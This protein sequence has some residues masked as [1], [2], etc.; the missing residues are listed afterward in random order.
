MYHKRVDVCLLVTLIVHIE[1]KNACSQDSDM[2]KLT[3]SLP[4]V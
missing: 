2:K 1:K 4:K 3:T